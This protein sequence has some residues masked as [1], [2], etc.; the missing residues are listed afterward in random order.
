MTCTLKG[1][2]VRPRNWSVKRDADGHRTY[3]IKFLVLSDDAR[4]G[5]ATVL[6]TPGM[7]L[8]GQWWIIG[9]DIDEW[10]TCL[11]EMSI[12]PLTPNEPNFQW[13]VEMTFSTKPLPHSAQRCNEQQ[14]GDPLL[15]PAKI[16]GASTKNTE[17]AAFDRFG[18][19]ILNSAFEQMRGRQVEFDSN[20]STVKI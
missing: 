4:D 14:V 7:P 9:N 19:P 2:Q 17:E 8:P 15:E 1:G 12:T 16:S 13:E 6:N 20:R 3:T 18:F 11:P 10:A 5:P